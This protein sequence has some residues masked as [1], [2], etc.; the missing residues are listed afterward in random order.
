MI[1]HIEWKWFSR[2]QD[3]TLFRYHLP[4]NTFEYIEDGWMWVC[5]I[6]SPGEFFAI[7]A[8]PVPKPMH[9]CII[10]APGLRK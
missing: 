4:P 7:Y 1:A 9:R 6:R 10:T 2:I 8:E 3:Q 5:P